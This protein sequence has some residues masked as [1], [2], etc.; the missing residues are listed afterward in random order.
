MDTK[1][2]VTFTD[3]ELTS[4]NKPA[5]TGPI[6]PLKESLNIPITLSRLHLKETTRENVTAVIIHEVIHAYFVFNGLKNRLQTIEHEDMAVNYINPMAAYLISIY[7][8]P[9]K[10][11]VGLAWSGL[12]DAESYAKN[13][14]FKYSNGSLTK[15]EIEDIY[16]NFITGKSGITMCK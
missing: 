12:S 13:D 7:G 15:N 9:E 3:V 1:V 2:K 11:A 8:I 16:R 10:D 14:I 5:M 4:T 6:T